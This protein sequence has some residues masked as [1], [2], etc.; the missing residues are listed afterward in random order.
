MLPHSGQRLVT[1][2][3][4]VQAVAEEGD[5]SW[6]DK[7]E[8]WSTLGGAIFAAFAAIG[9]LW[10]IAQ[11]IRHRREDKY[12]AEIRQARSIFGVAEI[13][14]SHRPDGTSVIDAVRCTITNRSLDPILWARAIFKPI[15]QGEKTY[16]WMFYKLLQPGDEIMAT[17]SG[18]P[19]FELNVRVNPEFKW[20]GF[21]PL[22]QLVDV[23]IEFAD[24][25][26]VIWRRRGTG[27]PRKKPRGPSISEILIS[28]LL[29]RLVRPT[30]KVTTSRQTDVH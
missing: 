29:S 18:F 6:T 15:G 22:I 9:T 30:P 16:E 4:L 26:N 5:P 21:A 19:T 25:A 13:H 7:L 27:E 2:R 10:L 3:H 12:E 11:G 1:V 17:P 20:I 8:A 24:H 28:H 23:E 14:V